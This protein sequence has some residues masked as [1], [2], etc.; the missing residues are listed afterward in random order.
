M[1]C[2][3]VR[4]DVVLTGP[5]VASGAVVG[6][7]STDEKGR[8]DGAIVIPRDFALGDY[9]LVVTTPGDARCGPGKSK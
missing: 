2:A 7:L 5:A 4:V 8:Y 3:H 9:E 1:P 6:S